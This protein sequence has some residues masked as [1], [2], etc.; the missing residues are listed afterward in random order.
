MDRAKRN[1]GNSEV[2]SERRLV[3]GLASAVL[4]ACQ[5]IVPNAM[6]TNSESAGESASLEDDGKV[7]LAAVL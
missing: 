7:Y 1:K 6:A 3:T 2:Q 4:I 5:L